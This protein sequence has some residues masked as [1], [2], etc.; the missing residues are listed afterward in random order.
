[1]NYYVYV[2]KNKTRYY[3]GLT[4]DVFGRYQNA[5]LKGTC[6]SS[7]KLGNLDDLKLYHYWMCDGYILASKLERSLHILQNHYGK[8]IVLQ[9]IDLMPYFTI[10]FQQAINQEM[11]S[12]SYEESKQDQ[13]DESYIFSY[14]EDEVVKLN[15]E[16]LHN[17]K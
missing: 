3:V 16:F 8:N 10:E 14:N 6:K 11:L 4:S 9:I 2:L 7:K 17:I 13:D 1:M 15:D 12:T 5:H